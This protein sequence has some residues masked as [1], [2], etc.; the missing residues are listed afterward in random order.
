LFKWRVETRKKIWKSELPFHIS[1][2]PEP[3]KFILKIPLWFMPNFIVHNT[4]TE[5]M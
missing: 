3:P 4:R 1:L 5:M 2:V